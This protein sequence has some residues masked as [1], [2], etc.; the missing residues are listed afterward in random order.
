MLIRALAV[1]QIAEALHQNAACEQVGQRRD[2]LA[3]A[4]RLVKRLREPV[5]NQK[6]KVCILTAKRRVCIRVPVDGVDAL[7]VFRDDMSIRVHAERAHLIAVLLGPVNELRLIDD[8]RD[9]LKHRRRKLN[10]HTDVNLVVKKM[11]PQILTHVGE[12]LR[13]ASARCG[14]QIVAEQLVAV[15]ER[16]E[17]AAV[18][19]FDVRRRGIE[20][21]FEL[22]LEVLIDVLQNH[23]VFLGAEMLASCLQ[24]VQII[25]QR[26]SCQRLCLCSFG[27]V[28][29]LSRAVSNVDGVHVLDEIHDRAGVHEVGQPTAEG[30]RKIEL[31]VGERARAAEAAHCVTDRAVDALAHLA[32]DNR[33]AS[34]VDIGSLVNCQQLDSGF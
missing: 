21:E 6:R 12:P 16:D 5:R 24:Q 4:I 3:V 19:F 14:K 9:M 10:A 25:A 20:T 29:L 32:G 11:Q 18:G 13:A 33:T 23:E 17:I 26:P 34:V 22:L 27:G 31:A 7:D 15:F 8:V 2:V 30:G 1:D 28:D